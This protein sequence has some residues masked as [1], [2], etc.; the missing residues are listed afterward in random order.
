[1]NSFACKCQLMCIL[2]ILLYAVSAIANSDN[3]A[4]YT[5]VIGMIPLSKNGVTNNVYRKIDLLVPELMKFSKKRI[6]KLECR[7]NGVAER[8][9]D[10]S[11]AFMIAGK[12][13]KYLRERHKLNMNVWLTTQIGSSRENSPALTF[14]VFK[15]EINVLDA[16]PANQEKTHIN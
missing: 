1:M 11:A 2:I 10:V 13:E 14:S 3:M 5:K 7:Y 16:L 12:V 8:E 9:Q 6:I 4:E 15:N